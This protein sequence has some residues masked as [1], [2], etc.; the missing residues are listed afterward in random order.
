MFALGVKYVFP[1]KIASIG[2]NYGRLQSANVVV[3]GQK[4]LP[5][6]VTGDWVAHLY[7]ITAKWCWPQS[8]TG[9]YAG[10]D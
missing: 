8:E 2:I 9:L 7:G 10:M 1:D 3:V 6:A 5:T 4:L